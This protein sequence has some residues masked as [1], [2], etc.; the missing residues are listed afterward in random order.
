LEAAGSIPWADFRVTGR[1]PSGLEKRLPENVRLTGFLEDEEYKALLA[2][3]DLV[4]ALTT[5]AGTLL[6]GAQEA[7]ALHKPLVLSKTE[8]LQT[9]FFGGSV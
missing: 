5:R 3:A 2:D 9:Y 7:V 6:F 1:A 8:T 4:I